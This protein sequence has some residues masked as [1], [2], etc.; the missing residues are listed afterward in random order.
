MIRYYTVEIIILENMSDIQTT[1]QEE[2]SLT[3][4][5]ENIVSANMQKNKKNKLPFAISYASYQQFLGDIPCN[6]LIQ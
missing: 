5:C 1:A 6:I 3:Y 4:I 2:D